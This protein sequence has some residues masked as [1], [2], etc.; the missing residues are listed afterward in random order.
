MIGCGQGSGLRESAEIEEKTGRIVVCSSEMRR[1][2][3]PALRGCWTVDGYERAHWGTPVL[4][5]FEAAN[6]T[7]LTPPIAPVPGH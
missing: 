6:A 4:A 3:N 2:C 5:L 7:E 1:P